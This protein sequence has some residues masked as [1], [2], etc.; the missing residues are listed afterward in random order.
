MLHSATLYVRM[1]CN[2]SVFLYFHLIH[3]A[4]SVLYFIASRNNPGTTVYA[5]TPVSEYS[6]VPRLSPLRDHLG[7]VRFDHVLDVVTA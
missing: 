5:A 4:T 3:T 1:S 2:W 6:L 7:L